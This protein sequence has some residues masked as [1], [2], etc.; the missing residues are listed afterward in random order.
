MNRIAVLSNAGSGGNR[1]RTELLRLLDT[2]S[3]LDH[4]VTA[5]ADELPEALSVLLAREPA[6][7]AVNGGDGT[8]QAVLTAWA[9]LVDEGAVPPAPVPVAVLPAGST[10]MTAHDLGC[11]GRMRRRLDDLL[12]LRDRDRRAWQVEARQPLA[13][14]D[15]AGERRLGFF[16]GMGT[17]VRGIEYWHGR[18]RHGGGAGEWGA[19]AALLRAA[20]GIVRR[21]PPFHEPARLRL[22]AEADRKAGR[23]EA[24]QAVTFLL[25]TTMRRLF[26]G[27]APFWGEA[28]APLSVTWVEAGARRFLPRIPALLAGR[29]AHL[30]AADGYHGLRTDRLGLSFDDPWAIDGEVFPASASLQLAPAPA[31]PFVRLVDAPGARPEQSP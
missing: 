3:G 21:E 27:I 9:A 30:P 29:E 28:P 5:S 19:G 1:R 17:I 16:F 26:L 22:V 7:L 6:L 24:E 2:T 10:N 15:G 23:V 8:V 14:V 20:W 18:L 13:V 31:Q 11:G 12:A 25:A 4:R